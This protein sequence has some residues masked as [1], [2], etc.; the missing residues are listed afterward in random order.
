[1]ALNLNC[2]VSR[3]TFWLPAAAIDWVACGKLVYIWLRV[4]CMKET[5][6]NSNAAVLIILQL[7]GL[8]ILDTY[9]QVI[10]ST[11]DQN[12]YY[13]SATSTLDKR[14]RKADRHPWEAERRIVLSEKS[15]WQGYYQ[16]YQPTL[17]TVMIAWE[18]EQIR[19]LENRCRHTENLEYNTY[20]MWWHAYVSSLSAL[21]KLGREEKGG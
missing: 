1:M 12:A 16:S 19:E 17:T 4:L 7:N 8:T 11:V 2:S 6:R 10:C 21:S 14:N 15:R 20:N 18:N 3:K 13:I 5:K 9:W